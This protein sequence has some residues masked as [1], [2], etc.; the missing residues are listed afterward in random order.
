VFEFDKS[1]KPIQFSIY[2]LIRVLYCRHTMTVTCTVC[3]I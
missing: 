2:S 3:E 1:C